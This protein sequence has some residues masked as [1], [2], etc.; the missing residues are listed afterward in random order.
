MDNV[1]GKFGYVYNK[2]IVSRMKEF[3]GEYLP[4]I[5]KNLS[6]VEQF[7][8]I[9]KI[10]KSKGMKIHM[11][12]KEI[13]LWKDEIYYIVASEDNFITAMK[14]NT[15]IGTKEDSIFINVEAEKVSV[16][17]CVEMLKTISQQKQGGE[18]ADGEE[19]TGV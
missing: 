13:S 10:L 6:E 3:L 12:R 1:L 17:D 2:F 8:F 7:N 9:N 14:L 4:E 16:S 15:I 11:F 18:I 5:D 19:N